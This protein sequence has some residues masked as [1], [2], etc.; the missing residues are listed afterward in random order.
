MST[1]N[2]GIDRRPTGSIQAA[3]F[4]FF[5][6]FVAAA[7]IPMD[8]GA[9]TYGPSGGPGYGMMGGRGT[10][11]E[12]E[13]TLSQS[14]RVIEQTAASAQVNKARNQVIFSGTRVFIAMAAVQPGFPDTTFE[15]VGLVD[16]TI[17][18]TAGATV[19]LLLINMDFGPDMSHGVV[20]TDARPPYPAVSMMGMWGALAGIPVLPP[21]DRDN[22]KA[23]HYAAQSVTFTAPGS[24]TSYYYL[25][26][27]RDHASK[28]MFGRFEVR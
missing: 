26:Q 7:L 13:L 16:P 19:T 21:R 8:V 2:R 17:E 22:T 15:V 25:C 5:A 27:Y 3:V 10:Q 11:A 12:Q 24:G 6:A 20:V 18:V 28:G 14:M 1:R 9:Q 4:T 23:A